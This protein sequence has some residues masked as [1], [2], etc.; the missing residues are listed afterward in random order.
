VGVAA[1]VLKALVGDVVIETRQVEKQAKPQMV[2]RF[3]IN[4][5]LALAVLDR[6]RRGE[7]AGTSWPAAC[8]EQPDGLAGKGDA[9]GS[10]RAAE[11]Q[12][13]SGR[14][15]PAGHTA[16]RLTAA[17]GVTMA[18]PGNSPIPRRWASPETITPASQ[19][20]AVAS[21]MSSSGSARIT[22]PITAGTTSCTRAAYPSNRSAASSPCSASWAANFFRNRTSCNSPKSG[23]L[24]EL[25]VPAV[26]ASIS[27]PGTLPQMSPDTA[28]FVSSTSRTAPLCTIRRDLGF[29]LFGRH[30]R[31]S[32]C[33]ELLPRR[34]H[35]RDA[36]CREPLRRIAS[37]EPVSSKPSAA[38]SLARASEIVIWTVVMGSYFGGY[39][40]NARRL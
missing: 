39:S 38:A 29:D 32:S 17:E 24:E 34:L 3:T 11:A 28:V 40:A 31:R 27:R 33:R 37:I 36:G 5:V 35:L 6:G 4:A 18:I 12:M 2:A 21:T 15:R 7:T 20:T 14:R 30:R 22:G 25:A 19:A 26:A 1:Q 8:S 13:P 16:N 10:G 23:T 9:E